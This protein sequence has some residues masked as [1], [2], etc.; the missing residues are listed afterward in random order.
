[1]SSIIT[2]IATN[3]INDALANLML[4]W[5]WWKIPL[6]ITFFSEVPI[7]MI[8]KK[9]PQK[10]TV[11]NRLSNHATR[12][13]LL[14]LL[15]WLSLFIYRFS[16]LHYTIKKFSY[17][18][19]KIFTKTQTKSSRFLNFLILTSRIQTLSYME[20]LVRNFQRFS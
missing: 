8:W 17:I 6:L 11:K 19:G 9:L 1:L 4:T 13:F 20:I 15:N 16:I 7:L 10:F 3:S 5:S 12:R 14:T 18:L 2:I